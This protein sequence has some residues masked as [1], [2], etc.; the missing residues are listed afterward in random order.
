M[1]KCNS[2]DHN[3]CDICNA[4][5]LFLMR[6]NKLILIL[7]VLLMLPAVESYSQQGSRNLEETGSRKA[8]VAVSDLV[9]KPAYEAT[10]EGMRFKVWIMSVI[11]G[12]KDTEIKK[13]EFTEDDDV[14]QE[15][16]HVMIE[17][18]DPQNGYSISDASVELRTISPSGEESTIE[19]DPMMAQYGGNLHFAEK[20]NYKLNLSVNAGGRSILTPFTYTVN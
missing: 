10:N 8:V 7:S 14:E 18:F 4:K 16:H 9:A 3:G 6:L 12:L 5:L 17:I 1:L 19:L 11:K 2:P 20:G 15:T 13:N